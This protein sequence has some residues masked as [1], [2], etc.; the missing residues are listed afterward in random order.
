GE[1]LLKEKLSLIAYA[2]P[3][4]LAKLTAQFHRIEVS[5]FFSFASGADLNDSESAIGFL[6][7]GTIGL[8]EPGFYSASDAKSVDIRNHYLAHIS[9]V[10][11]ILGTDTPAAD[12]TAKRI[13]AFETDLATKAYSLNDQGDPSKINHPMS[14]AD[15]KRL[16]PAFDWDTYWAT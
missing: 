5:P 15:L 9:K 13:L 2:K 10:F 8:P 1:S 7:Q 11:Q 3:A 6:D 14:R 16:V 12:A 4:E